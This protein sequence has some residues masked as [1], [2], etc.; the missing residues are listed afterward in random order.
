[1]KQLFLILSILLLCFT[2]L[3]LA[4]QNELK[5]KDPNGNILLEVRDEGVMVKKVTTAERTG[6]TLTTTEKGLLV[7]DT[8][9]SAFFSWDGAQWVQ[10]DGTDLVDDADADP[11][12]ELQDIS[13]SGNQLSITNGSTVELT[14]LGV[15]TDDQTLSL[16]GSELSISEGNT[17]D[18]SNIDINLSGSD[19]ASPGC[20]GFAGKLTFGGLQTGVAVS[21][22]YAYVISSNASELNIVDISIPSAPTVTGTLPG[23]SS[24]FLFSIVV[25]GNYA[26]VA[27]AGLEQDLAVIDVSNPAAP[28]LV[29]ATPNLG[30]NPREVV[31]RDNY[32]YVALAG[33]FKVVDVSNPATPTVIESVNGIGGWYLAISGDY[34]YISDYINSQLK[35]VNIANPAAPTLVSTTPL[36]YQPEEIAIHGSYVYIVDYTNEELKIIDVSDP[37]APNPVGSFSSKEQPSENVYSGGEI[38]VVDDLAYYLTSSFL[39]VQYGKIQILDLSDPANPTLL[40]TI[41]DTQNGFKDGFKLAVADQRAFATSLS[42]NPG[43]L[44]IFELC[45]QNIGFGLNPYTD[46]IVLTTPIYQDLSLSGDMLSLTNDATPVDLSGFLDNTD[47]Q[48]LALSGT[49]LTLT[50]DDTAVDLSGFLDNTDNQDLSLSGNTL[51]LTN[52]GT[53]VDLSGFLDNTDNQDLSLSGNTL[54]LTNDGTPV[55]LSAFLDSPWEVNGANVYR[56]N[57]NIGI[58]IAPPKQNWRSAAPSL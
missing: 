4:A 11:T 18:L 55:N 20:P 58:G 17:V 10:I 14:G 24:S 40:K 25:N 6:F 47:N 22:N 31:I 42:S 36:G 57:G 43:A 19:L 2:S 35:I 16:T 38:V 34:A 52:D 39:N 1:M 13:L 41:T 3:E 8:D 9:L 54:S 51:S 45:P 50:N 49:A 23:L 12:N 37:N 5:V 56:I 33:S 26:Y 27:R 53:P 28:T 15:D 44:F 48:D 21:G 29:G 30:G 46:E 32:A 7:Y